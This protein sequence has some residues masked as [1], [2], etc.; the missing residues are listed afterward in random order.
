MT[1]QILVYPILTFC[2]IALKI[3]VTSLNKQF[4]NVHNQETL[5][6]QQYL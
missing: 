4:S 6:H 3:Q 1:L 5:L 2:H